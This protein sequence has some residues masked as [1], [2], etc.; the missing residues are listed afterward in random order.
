LSTPVSSPAQACHILAVPG[1]NGKSSAMMALLL[2]AS[3]DR[4]RL[5]I[6]REHGPRGE[7]INVASIGSA[8]L[9]R[10][11]D[12]GYFNRVYAPDEVVSERLAEVEAFYEGSP[13]GCE[14]IGPTK[15]SS[16]CRI[17]RECRRH[18]W[19][20]GGCYAWLAA[21]RAMITFLERPN[22]FEIRPPAETEQEL[23]LLSY[24]RGFEANPDRF[25]AAVQNMRHLFKRPDLR[26]LMAYRAGKPAGVGMLYCLGNVAVLCAG[27]TLPEHR[28]RGCHAALL[29][30]RIRLAAEHGCE[31]IFSWAAAGGQSH[32]NMERAGLRTVGITSAWRLP[33]DRE[34]TPH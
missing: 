7:R 33:P 10:F 30:A 21:Q 32:A 11:D 27:A 8:T 29:E 14:L 15:G 9:L 5:Q 6:Y 26:F 4:L 25:P 31:S 12:V 24:L 28:R 20:Q 18:G 3:Y 22:C 34:R 17:D 16:S 1:S 23:F 19:V 13:F 2:F